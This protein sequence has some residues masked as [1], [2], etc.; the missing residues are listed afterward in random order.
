MVSDEG[1]CCL[2]VWALV[3]GG[4]FLILGVDLVLVSDFLG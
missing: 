2:V 1:F 4:G 3:D